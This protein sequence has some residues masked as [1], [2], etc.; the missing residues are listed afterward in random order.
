MKGIGV[1]WWR[2]FQINGTKGLRGGLVVDWS[3]GFL[4]W[5]NK[6][7]AN[8]NQLF[9]ES[10]WHIWLKTLV[11]DHLFRLYEENNI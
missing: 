5:P 9:E 6:F 2:R 11:N 3:S 8:I 4:N 1:F 7:D 10:R